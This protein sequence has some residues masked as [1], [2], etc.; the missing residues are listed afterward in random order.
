MLCLCIRVCVY[1]YSENK[2]HR[3]RLLFALF[4]LGNSSLTP[5]RFKKLGKILTS[6]FSYPV[7]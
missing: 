4:R 7:I 6:L 3:L 1:I 2:I 5:T